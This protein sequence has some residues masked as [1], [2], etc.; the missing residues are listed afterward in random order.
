MECR[1]KV[2]CEAKNSRKTFYTLYVSLILLWSHSIG[3]FSCFAVFFHLASRILDYS[4]NTTSQRG[5]LCIMF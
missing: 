3:I 5:N 1:K 2:K 4:E